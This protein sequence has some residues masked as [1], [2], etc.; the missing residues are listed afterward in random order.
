[1]NAGFIVNDY[2]SLLIMIMNVRK[3]RQKKEYRKTKRMN[4]T[5]P[6]ATNELLS[7]SEEESIIDN[8]KKYLIDI[9]K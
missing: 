4:K 5:E 2:Y 7:N 1:M 6:T 8:A 3:E 9:N